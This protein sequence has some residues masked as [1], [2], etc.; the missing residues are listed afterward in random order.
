MPGPSSQMAM[1]VSLPTT[2]AFLDNLRTVLDEGH[3]FVGLKNSLLVAVPVVLGVL[4]LGSMAA[5]T[6]A[7]TS[8]RSHRA[9]YPRSCGCS[10]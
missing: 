6:Y 4:L 5:W 7:R 2:W 10:R 8:R 9:I 3:Y 1:T